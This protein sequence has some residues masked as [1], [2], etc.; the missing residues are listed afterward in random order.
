MTTQTNTSDGSLTIKELHDRFKDSTSLD[1]TKDNAIAALE[2]LS[3]TTGNDSLDAILKDLKDLDFRKPNTWLEINQIIANTVN[4]N[5]DDNSMLDDDSDDLLDDDEAIIK[6]IH[7]DRYEL[8]NWI[9][10]LNK[11]NW[12]EFNSQCD[13][14][15]DK[16]THLSLNGSYKVGAKKQF[17][18][19]NEKLVASFN[20]GIGKVYLSSNYED[21]Y[22]L[23]IVDKKQFTP[24]LDNKLHHRLIRDI[25][26]NQAIL[27][28]RKA[29]ALIESKLVRA[30][31]LHNAREKV[32]TK[33]IEQYQRS[34]FAS[35]IDRA[36]NS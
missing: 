15:L 28:Y 6:N 33:Y 11:I 5:S 22:L 20:Y 2:H 32:K 27:G 10:K 14:K 17:E 30:N 18:Y 21:Y 34:M 29:I 8:S 13:L 24:S 1:A 9:Y 26:P 23:G 35:L 19:N 3:K 12:S 25:N 36:N 4:N 16:N 7:S 31:T